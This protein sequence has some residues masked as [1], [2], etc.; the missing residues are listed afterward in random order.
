[1]KHIFFAIQRLHNPLIIHHFHYWYCRSFCPRGKSRELQVPLSTWYARTSRNVR[2]QCTGH[3]QVSLPWE[4]LV[5]LRSRPR[6]RLDQK[7]SNVASF[8]GRKCKALLQER[9]S[10]G[11]G[12]D[13]QDNRNLRP[14]RGQTNKGED[15]FQTKWWWVV[16]SL[17]PRLFTHPMV[18]VQLIEGVLWTHSVTAVWIS[19][20]SNLSIVH[21]CFPNG[22][23]S[24]SPKAD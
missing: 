7:A 21:Q 9:W 14:A 4:G 12:D 3:H 6:T 13:H 17:S 19:T 2:S 16:R 23:L 18:D 22:V 10:S 15:L 24:L 5:T 1:M 11:T 20:D 8:L